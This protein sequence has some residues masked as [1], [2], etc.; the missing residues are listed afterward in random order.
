MGGY[1]H[2]QADVDAWLLI[3]ARIDAAIQAHRDADQNAHKMRT[4][5][6]ESVRISPN[7]PN[8]DPIQDKGLRTANDET[9]VRPLGIEPRT[10]GLRV[11]CSTS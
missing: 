8:Y 5:Q 6:D 2:R 3:A 10:C 1:R 9:M 4:V 7:Q 11:R